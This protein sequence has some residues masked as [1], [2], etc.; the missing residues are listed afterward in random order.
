MIDQ[1]LNWK[2]QHMHVIGKGTTWAS[3]IRRIARPSWGM[4]L[5]YAWRLFNSVAL[6]KLLYGV[7]IWCGPPIA[8][9]PGPKDKGSARPVR[10]LTQ[11]QHSGATAI[12]G[13]LHTAPT[14]TLNACAYLPPAIHTIDKWCHHVALHLASA[15]PKHPLHKLVKHSTSRYIR[16]H[17]SPLHALFNWYDFNHRHIEKIPFKPCNLA[18]KDKLPFTIRIPPNKETSIEEVLRANERV[19]VFS[20]G[21]AANNK[22]GAMAI[23]TRPGKSHQ[24]LHLHLGSNSKHTVHEAELVGILLAL[25]LIKTEK[26]G[27]TSFLIGVDNQATLVAFNSDMRNPA[28]SIAREAL[29][30]ETDCSS[31]MDRLPDLYCT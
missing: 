21:L 26:A 28:H 24:I 11:T 8:E 14:D 3:Q 18:C 29:C 10:Q 12:T 7:D 23:L 30:V 5:K 22:V 9:Y 2:A 19:Q 1:H 4:T 31:D 15:L 25:Q 13:A 20:D 6:P 16:R 17:R 27:Q